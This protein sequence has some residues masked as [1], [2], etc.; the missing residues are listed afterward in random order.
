MARKNVPVF[1]EPPQQGF[2]KAMCSDP[3]NFAFALTTVKTLQQKRV[4]G[5]WVLVKK[6]TYSNE[7]HWQR[8]ATCIKFTSLMLAYK[9]IVSSTLIYFLNHCTLPIVVFQTS[10]DT[11]GVILICICHTH[12]KKTIIV[13]VIISVIWLLV[14]SI[15]QLIVTL[16][17]VGILFRT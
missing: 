7:L 13:N 8:L 6:S 17:K 5:V 16:L 4:V 14:L 2:L 15:L 9:V 12:T 10:S 1:F 3:F 11:F